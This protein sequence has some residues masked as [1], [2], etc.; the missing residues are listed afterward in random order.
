MGEEAR[1]MAA[2]LRELDDRFSVEEMVPATE[3]STVG[4]LQERMNQ[5]HKLLLTHYNRAFGVIVDPAVFSALIRRIRELEAQVE[6]DETRRL[7]EKRTAQ[8]IP[9]E[10]W[11]TEEQFGEAM[12]SAF[13]KA[14]KTS[15]ED[16]C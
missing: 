9:E 14:P 12:T 16:E 6:E 11:L 15:G 3:L 8:V 4:K 1:D 10:A 7:I 5:H 13:G 2:S